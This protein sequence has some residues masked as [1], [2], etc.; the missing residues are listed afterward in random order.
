MINFFEELR[1]YRDKLPNKFTI[2]LGELIRK[3]RLEASITQ[4][5]LAERAY[6]SQTAI[7]QMEQGKRDVSAAE[8]IYLS[9]ALDKPILYFYQ[10][11]SIRDKTNI[12]LS[13]LENVLINQAKK[14]ST[15]DLRKLVAQTRAL[16]NLNQSDSQS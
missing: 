9:I 8:I 5:E 7:S 15:D 14:L 3:A 13:P 4:S 10:P 16:V 1:G 12:E 6:F 11:Y 2:Q